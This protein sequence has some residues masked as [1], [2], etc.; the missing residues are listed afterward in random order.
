MFVRRQILA[1]GAVAVSA[2]AGAILL[3]AAYAVRPGFTMEMDR[4]QPAIVSGFHGEERVDRETFA[5]TGRQVTMRL[6]GLDRRGPW[7]CAIRLRGGRQDASTL[8]EAIIAVDGIV[9]VRHQ[10]GNDFSDLAVRLPE[11]GSNGA[12]ITLTSSSTF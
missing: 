10:T 11:S 1:L 12:V 8:P 6:P 5:W 2:A 3:W 4:P 7:D 9:T